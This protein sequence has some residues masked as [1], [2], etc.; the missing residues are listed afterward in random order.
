[1]LICAHPSCN[2]IHDYADTMLCHEMSASS[3]FWSRVVCWMWK[4]A[5]TI[6][7]KL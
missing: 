3:R 6:S 5:M 1:M 4:F 7:G 2:P